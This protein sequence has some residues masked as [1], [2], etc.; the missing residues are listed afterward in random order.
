MQVITLAQTK[1]LLGL[2][3]DDTTYDTALSAAIPFIDSA[4]K[5]ITGNRWNYRVAASFED[6]ATSVKIL[7]VV[8]P[9]FFTSNGYYSSTD[10]IDEFLQ[11]GQ[12]ISATGIPA[13]AYITEV[14]YNYPEGVIVSDNYI[15]EV[16]ISETT[17]ASGDTIACYLGIPIAYHP[18]IAKAVWWQSQR[19]NTTIDDT[20]WTSKSMGPVSVSKSDSD[21]RIDQQ[22]G[23]PLWF[24][25]AL[26]RYMSGH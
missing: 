3:T 12:L 15:A 7:S 21:N 10:I 8:S 17:T 16:D 1:T 18:V 9:K 23:M 11:V 4:V 13:G 20:S 19:L 14:Y 5:Q 25:K 2:A 6:S 26:P 24:V 22:S